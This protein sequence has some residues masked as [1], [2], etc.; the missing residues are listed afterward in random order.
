MTRVVALVVVTIISI[1]CRSATAF[2]VGTASALKVEGPFSARLD[3]PSEVGGGQAVSLRFVLTN[4]T[5]D[6]VTLR[7]YGMEQ[8]RANF[9]VSRGSRE[10]WEKLR[11]ATMLESATE[12]RIAPSDSVVFLD[13]W[14]RTTNHR[15]PASPGKYTV[16]ARIPGT[17][18][19]SS[20]VE[21][22]LR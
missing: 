15:R 22:R 17:D 20:P 2:T 13:I 12:E 10:I 5:K 14:R 3:V 16:K 11:G 21:F 6:T 1:A 9:L 7:L 4:I 18:I 19:V 8:Q